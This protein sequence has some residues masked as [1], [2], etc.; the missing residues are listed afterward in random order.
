MDRFWLEAL[1]KDTVE[2]RKHAFDRLERSSLRST[3]SGV[4]AMSQGILRTIL[5]SWTDS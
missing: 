2:E 1:N 4:I 3:T 5:Y